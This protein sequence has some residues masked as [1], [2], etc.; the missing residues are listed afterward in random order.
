MRSAQGERW[1]GLS[2]HVLGACVLAGLVL[3]YAGLCWVALYR[4]DWLPSGS[5]FHA[6][7]VGPPHLLVWGPGTRP[8]F[9][10]TTLAL[11]AALAVGAFFR[12]LVLPVAVLVLL[13]WL[14]AGFF[15]V[16]LSV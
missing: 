14:V 8:L 5:I 7:L 1:V 12:V 4:P 16:A 3:A 9:W 11:A 13:I 6:S 2:P 15:S 10:M